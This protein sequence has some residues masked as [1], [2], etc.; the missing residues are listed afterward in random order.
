MA[1]LTQS[2]GDWRTRTQAA[3]AIRQRQSR[4]EHLRGLQAIDEYEAD[5]QQR[6]EAVSQVGRGEKGLASFFLS[7][8]CLKKSPWI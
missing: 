4:E 7:F 3:L 6:F 1:F 8:F 2:C 5:I